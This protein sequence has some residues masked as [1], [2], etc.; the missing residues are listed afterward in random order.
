[1]STNRQKVSDTF[2][3]LNRRE[4][5]R[6]GAIGLGGLGLCRLS[7][8]ATAVNSPGS[9]R[10]VILLLM[11]G[12]PSQLETWDP[13]PDAPTEI[14]GPHRSIATKIPGV[15][16]NEYLPKLAQRMDRLA[17]IRSVH[18]DASPIHET[19][20]QLLQTG[21]ISTD[22]N[23]HPS[24]GALASHV[25]GPRGS[26]PTSVVL[27]S[28]I[29]NTG[30]MIP[31]GQSAGWLSAGHRPFVVSEDPNSPRFDPRASLKKAQRFL[32]ETSESGAGRRLVVARRS[33]RLSSKGNPFNLSEE[34]ERVRDEYG[35]HT[36]GQ[37]CLMARR[38]VESGVRVVTVNMYQTVFNRV[39]W[40]CHG[41]RP[42]ST[43][44]DYANEVLPMFDQAFSTLLDDLGRSGRLEST[45]VLATGEFGRSPKVNAAGGRDHW[46]DVWSAAIAGGGIRGGQVLGAS[47]ATASS[48]ADRPVEAT[49][50]FATLLR[51][52]EIDPSSDFTTDDGSQI[53]LV[54]NATAIEELFV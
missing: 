11:V 1:M 28:P 8:A 46:P 47:D 33:A 24:L 43:L 40:D 4:A 41:A 34:P 23:E 16:I 2:T 38:L 50:L 37:S 6:M 45:M 27:P 42:F 26:M 21:R 48:P 39:S 32:T 22:S 36:F 10:S 17:L 14:R 12:G 49:E 13:K 20:Q 7:E 19:G 52:L 3:R 15:R 53:P 51:G 18:H 9:G 29:G 25:L 35:R 5:L 54:E 30:V 31:H 44:D